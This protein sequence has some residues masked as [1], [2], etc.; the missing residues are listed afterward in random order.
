MT[1]C[2]KRARAGS[3][4]ISSI[5]ILLCSFLHVSLL[6]LSSIKKTHLNN[7]RIIISKI[8]LSGINRIYIVNTIRTFHAKKVGGRGAPR[9]GKSCSTIRT[10]I[11]HS[12]T[13][14]QT[15]A[16]SLSHTHTQTHTHGTLLSHSLL[17]LNFS[18]TYTESV[19]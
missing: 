1:L 6:S 3:A 8:E 12:H 2:R 19:S 4:V 14:I 18:H 17:N 10:S 15:L 9:N 5:Q 7:C 16:L 11:S 13:L